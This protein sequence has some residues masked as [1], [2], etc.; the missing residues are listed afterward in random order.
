MCLKMGDVAGAGSDPPFMTGSRT[1][2]A[3]LSHLLVRPDLGM[4]I[5]LVFVF[6]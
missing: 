4:H 5:S 1:I 2:K 6:S 3:K